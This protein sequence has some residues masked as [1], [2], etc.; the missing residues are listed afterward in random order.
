MTSRFE[1]HVTGRLP[2]A[3]AETI[4]SRYGQVG[5]REQPKVTVLS[6]RVPDQAALRSLRGLIW[7][8][9]GSVLSVSLDADTGSD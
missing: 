6:G 1:V 5:M 7:D 3:L 2:R 9:G 8:S 4:G